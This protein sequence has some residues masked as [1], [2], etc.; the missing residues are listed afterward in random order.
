[1]TIR[2][3]QLYVRVSICATFEKGG[4]T[5]FPRK[6]TNFLTNGLQR[7]GLGTRILRNAV[8][9]AGHPVTGRAVS[10]TL[11]TGVRLWISAEE[12][13]ERRSDLWLATDR[14]ENQH[15]LEGVYQIGEIPDVLRP[16]DRP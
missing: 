4:Q 5:H 3:V 9:H 1:M 11:S 12:S 8:A 14:R 13:L 15:P 7:R 6:R 16:A 10:V 2:V